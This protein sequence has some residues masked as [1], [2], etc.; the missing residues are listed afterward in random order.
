MTHCMRRTDLVRE[1][2]VKPNGTATVAV[3]RG[4]LLSEPTAGEHCKRQ[5]L[6]VYD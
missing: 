5:A 4:M 6:E 3:F 2:S 1:A